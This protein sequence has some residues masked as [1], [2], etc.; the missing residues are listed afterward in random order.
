MSAGLGFG[1]SS[2]V[3][4]FSGKSQKLIGSNLS[5][6]SKEAVDVGDR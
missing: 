3:N 6:W 2:P 4:M 1:R 5:C